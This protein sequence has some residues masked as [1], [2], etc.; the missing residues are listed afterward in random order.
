VRGSGAA[1]VLPALLLLAAGCFPYT[2][3]ITPDHPRDAARAYV[4]GRF[5]IGGGGGL[6]FEINCSDQKKYVI[7]FSDERPFQVIEVSP[8]VCQIEYLLF[9]AGN[10]RS[11][12]LAPFRLLRNEFL[13]PGGVYYVGDFFYT[14]SSDAQ[15]RVLYTE[16][17]HT[18][19]V[20]A[21]QD[22]Y[23]E[24]TAELKRTFPSFATAQTEN[25]MTSKRVQPALV[26]QRQ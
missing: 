22:N 13:E 19:K 3:G 24:T 23:A 21:I 15:W 2:Q 12:A 17:R 26:P 9:T 20:N 11:R 7:G 8:S 10:V 5:Q 6:G 1:R 14:T 16:V 4:Y 18:W 25:R